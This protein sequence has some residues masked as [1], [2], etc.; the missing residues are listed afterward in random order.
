MIAEVLLT[1]G[2]LITMDAERRVIEDGWILVRDGVIAEIGDASDQASE[3]A[4]GAH[5]EVIDVQGAVVVP[6]FING[7]THQWG[8]L[9]K[10][11]GEGML[12]EEWISSV[13]MPLGGTLDADDVRVSSALSVAEQLRGGTTCS[14]NHAVTANDEK[15]LTAL[16]DPIVRAGARQLVTKEL[17]G[18]P[19]QAFNPERPLGIARRSVRDE[20]AVAE[21]LIERFDDPDNRI[22]MGLAIDT[23]AYFL[24]ENRVSEELVLQGV[25]LAERRNLRIT[26]HCSAGTPSL[27]IA[28]LRQATGGGD[29]DYL[30]GIGAMSGKWVLAHALHLTHE[31]IDLVAGAGAAVITNPVSNAYSCDG[32]APLRELRRAGV[33]IGLGSDGAYVNGTLDMVEQ[34]KFAVLIQNVVNGDPTLMFAED[35]LEMATIGSARALGLDHLIGSLEVG[36]RADIACFDLDN[37]H[38]TVSNHTVAAMVFS[39]R[40]TDAFLVLVDGRIVLRDG[41]LPG[42]PDEHEMLVEA[43]IRARAALERTGLDKRVERPWRR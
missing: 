37:A 7:H 8:S 39:A 36:K 5:R 34:M 12:L 3:P 28:Q 18:A 1:H 26:N 24:L 9:F 11:T 33:T 40:G 4:A 35:A 21:E 17:R 30:H 15:T 13:S 22:H 38:A 27:S 41:V 32:I 25:A 19:E 29:I 20:L 10:N 2:S 23:G 31:E 16:I 14:L 6:G 42:L 43:R